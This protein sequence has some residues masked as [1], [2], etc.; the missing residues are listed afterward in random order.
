M[1]G[2]RFIS[3]ADLRWGAISTKNDDFF[4]GS[5]FGIFNSSYAAKNIIFGTYRHRYW[6]EKKTWIKNIFVAWRNIVFAENIFQK[7]Q[8]FLVL[9]SITHCNPCTWI[10]MGI[11]CKTQKILCFFENDFP[12]KIFLHATKIFF[13]QVFFLVNIY[14]CTFQ[15]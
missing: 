3:W 7:T 5:V 12:R 4:C 6:P 2:E 10:T 13:I 9:H 1:V 11:L 8:Y 15:K 14:V